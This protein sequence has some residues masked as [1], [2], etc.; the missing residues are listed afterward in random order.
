[1]SK[2]ITKKQLTAMEKFLS[3]RPR[4]AAEL[5]REVNGEYLPILRKLNEDVPV[6][7]T[8]IFD[9]GTR[10]MYWIRPKRMGKNWRRVYG[11]LQVP[12]DYDLTV[13][14]FSPGGRKHTSPFA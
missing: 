9:N 10:F 5:I 12:H 2:R 1:M 6:L 11:T 7:A 8:T 13:A 14:D 4:A 3:K